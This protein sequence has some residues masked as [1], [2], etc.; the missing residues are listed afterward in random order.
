M[1]LSPLVPL[2]VVPG[3]CGTRVVRHSLGSC[4][5]NGFDDE[6]DAANVGSRGHHV[7]LIGEFPDGSVESRLLIVTRG[8]GFGEWEEG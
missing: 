3:G 8:N 2:L 6:D 4:P 7:T 1:D 5:Y